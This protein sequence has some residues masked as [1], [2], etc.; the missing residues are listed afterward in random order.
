MRIII[1]I[2]GFRKPYFTATFLAMEVPTIKFTIIN[3]PVIITKLNRGNNTC[4][5]FSLNIGNA[6]SYKI[7][8]CNK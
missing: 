6:A 1:T 4:T 5:K 3:F 8:R 7:E 2:A